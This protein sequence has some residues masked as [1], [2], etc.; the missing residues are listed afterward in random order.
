MDAII[1]SVMDGIALLSSPTDEDRRNGLLLLLDSC[2]SCYGDDGIALGEA[3]RT[4]NG[5]GLSLLCIALIDEDEEMR[6]HALLV[7]GNL[8]SDAVDAQSVDTKQMLFLLGAQD[9]LLDCLGSSDRVTLRFACA[10]LQNLCHEP[11]WSTWLLEQGQAAERLEEL[12][13]SEDAAISRYAS[14]ALLNL[15]SRTHS[16]LGDV[17]QTLIEQR[18]R[19]AA[20]ESFMYERAARRLARSVREMPHRLRLRRILSSKRRAPH[21]VHVP[22]NPATDAIVEE[23][24]V[25]AAIEEAEAAEAVEEAAAE[26]AAATAAIDQASAAEA[27]TAAAK[28]AQEAKDRALAATKLQARVRGKAKRSAAEKKHTGKRAFSSKEEV[29]AAAAAKAARAEAA[30]ARLQAAETA[31]KAEAAA[32]ATAA[33][34]TRLQAVQRGRSTRTKRRAAAAAEV[35]A[36]PDFLPGWQEALTENGERY[37]YHEE[38]GVSQWE[39]P[40]TKAADEKDALLPGWQEALTEDGEHY[41]YHEEGGASQW[42]K[43]VAAVSMAEAAA[44]TRLQAVQ[45]GRITRA[46]RQAETKHVAEEASAPTATSPRGGMI[47]R[48]PTRRLK[49]KG[50]GMSS[51]ELTEESAPSEAISTAEAAATARLQAVQRGRISRAKRQAETK[52]EAESALMVT[53]ATMTP[54]QVVPRCR[55]VAT[56]SKQAEAVVATESE[57]A[58][59]R[60]KRKEEAEAAA[61]A[62]AATAATMRKEAVQREQGTRTTTTEEEDAAALA[63]AA[64]VEAAHAAAAAVEAEAVIARRK[65]NAA[66]PRPP[67]PRQTSQQGRGIR[68]KT[69]AEEAAVAAAAAAAAEAVEAAGSAASCTA[70]ARP[71]TAE[72]SG[73]D[74]E[75]EALLPAPSLTGAADAAVLSMLGDQPQAA[76]VQ[77]MQY[78]AST[79]ALA[80]EL[81]SQSLRASTASEWAEE[82][83]KV[84]AEARRDAVATTR[85][86]AVH[87]GRSTRRKAS[88]LRAELLVASATTRLQA[89]Y[90]GRTTRRKASATRAELL[91]A[92]EAAQA[93]EDAGV[94]AAAMMAAVLRRNQL[95]RA[96]SVLSDTATSNKTIQSKVAAFVRRQQ[97]SRGLSAM[98]DGALVGRAALGTRRL[99]GRLRVVLQRAENLMAADTFLQGGKSD[100]YV[101]LTCGDVEKKS[102]TIKQNLNP[103]WNE[104]FEWEGH[105]TQLVGSGLHLNVMDYDRLKKDD[106]LGEVDV[107]LAELTGAHYHEYCVPLPTRGVVYFTVEWLSDPSQPPEVVV[108]A[109]QLQL[110]RGLGALR[111]RVLANQAIEI[112]A[113]AVSRRHLLRLGVGAL[114]DRVLASRVVRSEIAKR[115][116]AALSQEHAAQFLWRTQSA[117]AVFCAL[118]AFSNSVRHQAVIRRAMEYALHRRPWKQ[119]ASSWRTWSQQARVLVQRHRRRQINE[120][121]AEWHR[122]LHCWRRLLLSLRLARFVLALEQFQYRQPLRGLSRGWRAWHGMRLARAREHVAMLTI[123]QGFLAMRARRDAIH[124]TSAFRK[125]MRIRN[126]G[127]SRRVGGNVVRNDRANNKGAGRRIN[128]TDVARSS[129]Y[130]DDKGSRRVNLKDVVRSSGYGDDR[131]GNGRRGKGQVNLKDVVRSSGYGDDRGGNEFHGQSQTEDDVNDLA[132]RSRLQHD[133][134]R[135]EARPWKTSRPRLVEDRP[136]KPPR[137]SLRRSS[138]PLQSTDEAAS[139]AASRA[140]LMAAAWE[141]ECAAFALRRHAHRNRVAVIGQRVE[142]PGALPADDSRQAASLDVSLPPIGRPAIGRPVGAPLVASEGDGSSSVYIDGLIGAARSFLAN[143]PFTS[144]SSQF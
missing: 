17:A 125:W 22:T 106:R 39:R 43:P 119:L 42:E 118:L 2:E 113:T 8:S 137:P 67:P 68:I 96:V 66:A 105:K 84:E 13:R 104:S 29:E 1:I 15:A 62:A 47:N 26:R 99:S 27:A 30:A 90:R 74:S 143:Q 31:A 65:Q 48:S 123:A 37:Y 77:R 75:H 81:A 107:A 82:A 87:R 126:R 69:K 128:S 23:V 12:A 16:N 109:R 93:K 18:S 58:V 32:K 134:E 3:M 79:R 70:V 5:L 91:T 122:K 95:L 6:Q 138:Q 10:T 4:E 133:E 100:P 132:R 46:K 9:G 76:E 61:A 14:G 56:K 54:R 114:W 19:D 94:A 103:V 85:L 36:G 131:G 89:A 112:K 101:K 111:S 34:T 53:A 83:A 130:S 33:A 80:T 38:S 40:V 7:L 124:V 127:Y 98:R 135:S 60:R 117:A 24:E 129:G 71:Q 110:R 21:R 20:V 142:A 78:K 50:A 121:R 63:A 25:A 57:A 72:P 28:A 120:S 11:A 49:K 44:T 88:A 55:R 102:K 59:A 92:K 52:H 115:R 97:L 45:R 141:A 35:G 116:R 41:Y 86:Q 51:S 139:E 108:V 64:V 73:V 136:W 140:A 144:G